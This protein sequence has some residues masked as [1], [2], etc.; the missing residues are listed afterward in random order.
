MNTEGVEVVKFKHLG[1]FV[2]ERCQQ[3]FKDGIRPSYFH[4]EWLGR[5][6]D[7]NIRGTAQDGLGDMQR[8]NSGYAVWRMLKMELSGKK[9]RRRAQDSWI[10]GRRTC[11]MW[12]RRMLGKSEMEVNDPLWQAL[13]SAA[14]RRRRHRFFLLIQRAINRCML[15]ILCFR[16]F[17]V[18]TDAGTQNKIVFMVFQIWHPQF[19]L[20][21]C[22]RGCLMT[23]NYI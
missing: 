7:E 8:R 13:K 16:W 9:K 1:W 22:D 21:I 4:W 3:E 14:E 12:Q 10:W 6:R 15:T 18:Y 17:T 23:K 19:P 20:V 2:T 5:I 11:L